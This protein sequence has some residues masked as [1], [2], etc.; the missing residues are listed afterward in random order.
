MSL[1]LE[2]P[3]PCRSAAVLLSSQ[4]PPSSLCRRAAVAQADNHHGRGQRRLVYGCGSRVRN[5][6]IKIPDHRRV[7]LNLKVGSSSHVFY[8]V[9]HSSL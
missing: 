2:P 6:R 4:A 3:G 5:V 8:I 1:E 7:A 9:Q